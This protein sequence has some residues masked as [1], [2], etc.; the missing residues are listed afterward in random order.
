MPDLATLRLPSQNEAAPRLSGANIG[1]RP[2]WYQRSLDVAKQI[3]RKAPVDPSGFDSPDRRIVV[4][5]LAQCDRAL[6]L[7][8]PSRLDR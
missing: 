3:P 7:A 8:P 2:T 5:H 6:A 1:I 4:S